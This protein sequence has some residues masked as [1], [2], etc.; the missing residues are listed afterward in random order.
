MP[1]D[2]NDERFLTS[3]SQ[4]LCHS[5]GLPHDR[6][7][8]DLR[9]SLPLP[10]PHRKGLWKTF[11]PLGAEN[12]RNH[13]H[14]LRSHLF[15][16][17]SLWRCAGSY[18]QNST[19]SRYR[20][21][22]PSGRSSIP[23]SLP[24]R[25]YGS[26]NSPLVSSSQGLLPKQ[27]PLRCFAGVSWLSILHLGLVSAFS[28]LCRNS[29]LIRA[30]AIAAATV[31][32]QI[33]CIYRVVELAG[34]FRSEAANDQPAFMVLDGPMNMIA[35]G[36]LTICHPGPLFLRSG[37]GLASIRDIRVGNTRRWRRRCRRRV[38][39]CELAAKGWGE[40]G[41]RQDLYGRDDVQDVGRRSLARRLSNLFLIFLKILA[42]LI[43]WL[44][45]RRF[46]SI[47]LLFSGNLLQQRPPGKRTKVSWFPHLHPHP[48]KSPSK[49]QDPLRSFR[50]LGKRAPAHP[51]TKR[52]CPKTKP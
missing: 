7:C 42:F 22:C 1:S 30:L 49:D 47:R 14:L 33:R 34:G 23:S 18:R 20:R 10:R 35:V 5:T 3:D 41:A 50:L 9:A 2:I 11:L 46:G 45:R 31:T 15:D 8:P 28:L 17:P 37:H 12:I 4:I 21:S 26:R 44:A 25:L 29:R 39:M 48:L 16:P 40:Q 36:A 19:Q 32:I 6:P 52:H 27:Q 38:W 24:L 13:I 43:A 51:Q